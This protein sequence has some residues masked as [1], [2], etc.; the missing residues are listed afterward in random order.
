VLWRPDEHGLET[1][2]SIV[3]YITVGVRYM[4]EHAADLEQYN[5]SNGWGSYDWL[6]NFARCVGSACLFNPGCKI[7]ANR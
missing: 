3:G 2:D 6:L 4:E 7:E 5:P 1:T